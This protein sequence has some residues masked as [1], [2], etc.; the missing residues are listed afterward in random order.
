MRRGLTA[1]GQLRCHECKRI[2]EHGERYLLQ[3]EDG[4]EQRWCLDCCLKK[5]E[6]A[7]VADVKEKGERHITF[8]PSSKFENK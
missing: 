5:G 6:A 2:I 7:D 4:K 1:T 3:G 8:F